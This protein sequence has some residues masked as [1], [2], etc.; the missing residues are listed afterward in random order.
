MDQRIVGTWRMESWL[1]IEDDGTKKPRFGPGA[2][3]LLIYT[4]DGFMAASLQD[5]GRTS[6]AGPDPYAGTPEE[7]RAAMATGH[8]YS[9][10]WR[11]EG[12]AILHDVELSVFPNWVGSTQIRYFRFDGGRMILRTPPTHRRGSTGYAE[13]TWR[14]A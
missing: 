5:G 2:A 13:L 4:A 11:V 14:R 9:G 3:G 12:D 6:F 7:C 8:S 1:R 10:R